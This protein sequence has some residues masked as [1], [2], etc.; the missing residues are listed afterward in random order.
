MAVEHLAGK[1]ASQWPGQPAGYEHF[2][3]DDF[4]EYDTMWAGAATYGGA[5]HD[6]YGKWKETCPSFCSI[7]NAGGPSGLNN[8][9]IHVPAGTDWTLFHTFGQLWIAGNSANGNRGYLQ[10][11]FDGQ[12]TS[13]K[14][15]WLDVYGPEVPPPSGSNI[16]SIIDKQHLAL[17]LGTGAHQSVSV[18][19]VRVW[20]LPGQGTVLH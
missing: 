14:I 9:V 15:S 12:P 3:E 7:A 8:F 16:F 10:Y 1:G 17:V 19:R 5:V 4:F 18:K 6:W 20:Q 11:Y 13:D 2:I